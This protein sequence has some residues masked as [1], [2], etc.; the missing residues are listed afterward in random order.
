MSE[1]GAAARLALVILVTTRTRSTRKRSQL[2]THPAIARERLRRR[3]RAVVEQRVRYRDRDRRLRIEEGAESGEL[4][5]EQVVYEPVDLQ[6]LR[7]LV[8]AV[9]VRDPVVGELRVLV[10]VIANKPFANDPDDVGAEF[11]LRRDPVV[12]ATFDLVPRYA[13]NLLAWRDKD[14]SIC[15][16]ERIVR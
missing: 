16:R 10:G 2:R 8:R 5:I 11:Q 9:Q 15:V 3:D 7:E 1:D 14:V 6:L 13:G 12:D 4:A